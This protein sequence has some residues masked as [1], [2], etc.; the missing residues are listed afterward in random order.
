[1]RRAEILIQAK[2][3]SNGVRGQRS[4]RLGRLPWRRSA[5]HPASPLPTAWV[6]PETRPFAAGNNR[7]RIIEGG[8]LKHLLEEYLHIDVRIDLA[9]RAHKW[10]FEGPFGGSWGVG[11]REGPNS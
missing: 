9:R 2:R 11:A 8:E 5:Q 3:Y 10:P 6:R 7:L 4:P 1:V